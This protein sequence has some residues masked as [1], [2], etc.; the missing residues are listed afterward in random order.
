MDVDEYPAPVSDNDVPMEA[1]GTPDSSPFKEYHKGGSQTFGLG[2]TFMDNFHKDEFAQERLHN[3]YHP[4]ASADEWELASFLSNSDMSMAKIDHYLQLR[5][6]LKNNLSFR[7]AKDLRSRIESLPKGPNWK[8]IPWKTTYPTKRPLTLY[9]RDPIECLQALLSNP[10]V[11]DFIHFTPFRLWETADKLMRVFTEWLSGE[12]SFYISIEDDPDTTQDHYG[13]DATVLGAVLASDKTQLSRMTGNRQAHPLLITLANIDMD[14]R[15]KAVFHAFLLLALVP[16]PKFLVK[17]PEIRGMLESRLWHSILDYVLEPLKKTAEIGKMMNDPLGWRRFSYTPLVAYIVDTPEAAMIAGV[18]GKTSAVTTASYKNFGDSFRHPS[19]TAEHTIKRLMLLEKT[20]NP[21]NLPAYIKRAKLLRLNGVHRP[22][23]RNWL[24]ANPSEFLT[25]EILHHWIKMFYDHVL[26]WCIAAVGEEEIDF[27]FSVLR[28]HTG[29]RHF[30]DGVS[31]SKQVTMREGRDIMRYII[32]V[33]AEAPRVSKGFL[34]SISSINA[35][36]YRGQAPRISEAMLGKMDSDLEC[37]HKEKHAILKAGVRRGKKGPIDHWWIPKLESLINVTTSIRASGVPLQWSADV[38]EHSHITEVK[39]PATNSNNQGYES[40]IC[41]Y[42]DRRDKCRN[43]DLATAMDSAGVDLGVGPIVDD[44]KDA[45]ALLDDALLLLNRSSQLLEKIEP[46][47]QLSTARKKVNYFTSS[48]SLAEGDQSEVPQPFCT[49]ASADGSTAFHLNRDHVGNRLRVEEAA[50]KFSLPDLQEAL[51]AFIRRSHD[52]DDRVVIGGRRPAN[53]ADGSPDFTF[54]QV[55]H[56]VR[57]QA[58]S[59]HDRNQFLVPETINCEPPQ[60][61][62]PFGRG[63]PVVVN[64][65][66]AH[67]WPKSGLEGHAVCQLKMVFRVVPRNGFVS[68]VGTDQFL[69]YVQ[70][71]DIVSQIDPVT[72][73]RGSVPEPTTGM[74]QVKRARRADGSPMGDIVPLERLR[75]AV[76]LTPRF[77]KTANKRL[78]HATTLDYCEDF[79]LDHWYTKELFWTLAP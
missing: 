23:W 29:M 58:R 31:K 43:F 73:T 76:E 12:F 63:D 22:F 44:D 75:A 26:K 67:Q 28:R 17:N 6:T 32:A 57:M 70:R 21:W 39:D 77:G 50:K 27:R 62:W 5:M 7:T 20:L 2:D 10:L 37:F 71:F 36:F 38:T 46:V 35:F 52:A 34:K 45:D 30:N 66:P 59:Y 78:T 51:L 41:R 48:V 54:L 61:G 8:S 79:W 53:L 49:F 33:V 9:Y 60:A 40:Q 14:F 72:Q 4:F 69:A 19:R 1:L 15:M 42:L 25:P 74:Y 68:P 3:L 64:L 55:W 13:K 65:D 24:Y 56:H 18:A 16:I 47:A 11:Q